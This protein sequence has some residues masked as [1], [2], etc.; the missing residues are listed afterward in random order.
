MKKF[1]TKKNTILEKQQ[2]SKPLKEKKIQTK[3]NIFISSKY[4]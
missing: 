2:Q 3:I 4:N 1:M